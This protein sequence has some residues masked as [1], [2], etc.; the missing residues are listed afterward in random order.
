MNTF[1][2]AVLI[3]GAGGITQKEL[4]ALPMPDKAGNFFSRDRKMP[5]IGNINRTAKQRAILMAKAQQRRTRR[6]YL[7][8]RSGYDADIVFAQRLTA[9]FASGAAIKTNRWNP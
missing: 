5:H 7:D 3:L 6:R 1:L 8:A 4:D 9:G 2:A